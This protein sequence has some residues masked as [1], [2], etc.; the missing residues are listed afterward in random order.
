MTVE[1]AAAPGHPEL[2]EG[3]PRVLPVQ[4]MMP[5]VTRAQRRRRGIEGADCEG[6]ALGGE[7]WRLLGLRS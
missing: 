3:Q 6:Q 4:M 1:R 5:Y 7:I 2:V